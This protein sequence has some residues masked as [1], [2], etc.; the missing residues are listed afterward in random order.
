[1]KLKLRLKY[2][3]QYVKLKMKLLKRIVDS[4]QYGIST[5]NRKYS[6]KTYNVKGRIV[7]HT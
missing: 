3:K 4:M 2:L 6:R 1:M 5:I 7:M